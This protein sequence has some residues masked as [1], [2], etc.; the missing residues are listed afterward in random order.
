MIKKIKGTGSTG[1]GAKNPKWTQL[2]K[3]RETNRITTSQ[4]AIHM[5]LTTKLVM[6][7][8]QPIIRNLA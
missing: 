2:K 4:T 6:I 8:S 7:S 5:A 3:S 1:K